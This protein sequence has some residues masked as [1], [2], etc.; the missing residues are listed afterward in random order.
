MTQ[1]PFQKYS[2]CHFLF[3]TQQAFEKGPKEAIVLHCTR[4]ERLVWNKD[5]NLLGPFISYKENEVL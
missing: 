3:E 5:Y 2:N 4:L 1:E